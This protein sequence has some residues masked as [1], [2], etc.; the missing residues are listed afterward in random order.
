MNKKMQLLS[1]LLPILIVLF[2]VCSCR[3]EL[4]EVDQDKI[5]P[6]YDVEFIET[7]SNITTV[8]SARV[9]RDSTE[10]NWHNLKSKSNRPDLI[11]PDESLSYNGTFLGKDSTRIPII[12]FPLLTHEVPAFTP[13]QQVFSE[14][15]Q[16]RDFELTDANNKTYTNIVPHINE[17][18]PTDSVITL[19]HGVPT[20]ISWEGL[21]VQE[22][23]TVG[24]LTNCDVSTCFFTREILAERETASSEG[25]T[26]LTIMVENRD[27][28][29]ISEND[30]MEMDTFFWDVPDDQ[31]VRF[32]RETFHQDLDN[33][34]GEPTGGAMRA[35]YFSREFKIEVVQ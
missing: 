34:N 26:G 11:L 4:S 9:F 22:N 33:P 23:E 29:I 1:A 10:I 8:A 30:M 14:Y 20:L 25:A 5:F 16:E 27:T 17:I 6:V 2:T 19:Q 18:A 15:L 35:V 21:P 12:L 13:Y 28:T 7:D 31:R 3:K 32:Y 24:I